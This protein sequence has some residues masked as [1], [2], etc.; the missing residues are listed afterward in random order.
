MIW[1]GIW[2]CG[3]VVDWLSKVVLGEA[4]W[5]RQPFIF[6]DNFSGDTWVGWILGIRWYKHWYLSQF[7]FL[8]NR[9][10]KGN[11]A[12]IFD[13]LFRMFFQPNLIHL[14]TY[15]KSISISNIIILI[16][17]KNNNEKLGIAS[18]WNAHIQQC[19]KSNK[20]HKLI[21]IIY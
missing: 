3:W 16:N 18:K 5:T 20:N 9:D 2:F 7:Y 14:S 13:E 21:N 11:S 8:E 19:V 12:F 6:P 4:R 1:V 15:S 10:Q 17:Q